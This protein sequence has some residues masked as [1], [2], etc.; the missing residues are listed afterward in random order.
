MSLEQNPDLPQGAPETRLFDFAAP[1]QLNQRVIGTDSETGESFFLLATA[2]TV[3]SAIQSELA[4]AD[5]A[6]Y[7][8]VVARDGKTIFTLYSSQ[9]Y[10]DKQFRPAGLPFNL[11]PGQ[12][13]IY[14]YQTEGALLGQTL[15]TTFQTRLV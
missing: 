7:K 11:Q 15:Q 5:V 2:N 8:F 13:Q 3:L 4:T 1:T 14:M 12:Y 9:L 10:R 6:L